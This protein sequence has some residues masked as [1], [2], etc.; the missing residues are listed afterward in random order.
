MPARGDGILWLGGFFMGM[1][2]GIMVGF[3]AW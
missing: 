1:G 2:V 3:L